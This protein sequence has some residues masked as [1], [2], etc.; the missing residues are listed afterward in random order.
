MPEDYKGTM[1]DKVMQAIS[2][3]A[4]KPNGDKDKAMRAVYEVV[5]GEGAGKGH[6]D[7]LFLPM[8]SDMVTRVGLATDF[9]QRGLDAF[10]ETAD[11]VNID[12]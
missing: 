9:M 10:R 4:L 8:G 11:S 6:E 12:K 1:P 5:I 7:E 2:T 3:G